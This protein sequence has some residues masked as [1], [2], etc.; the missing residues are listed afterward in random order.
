[1]GVFIGGTASDYRLGTM[2]DLNNVPMFDSTGNHQSILAGR[3]SHY[4]DLQ[5]PCFTLDTAC[6]SGLIAMSQAVQ[7][8]RA[9][10]SDS[11]IVAGCKLNLQP[12]DLISMSNLG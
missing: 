7:S 2:R 8:I 4:F 3:I 9:G 1:M 5:G 12:D 10:E 11:A 6:S